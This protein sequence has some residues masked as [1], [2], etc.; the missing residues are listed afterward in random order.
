MGGV[1]ELQLIRKPDRD[2]NPGPLHA[3]YADEER[4]NSLENPI[5]IETHA[6]AS[7]LSSRV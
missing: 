5:G 1:Q 2:W 7:P 6:R 3:Y 4:Y